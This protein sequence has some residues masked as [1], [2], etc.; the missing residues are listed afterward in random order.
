MSEVLTYEARDLN[1]TMALGRR[2]GEL[3][4]PGATVALIGPLGAGKTQLAGAIAEGLGISKGRHVCSPTFTLI[5]EYEARLPI[6]HFDTYRLRSAE[7]FIDLGVHEYFQ[8]NGVCL[9]EW[10][11]RVE[12]VLPPDHLRI[13]IE[14]MG[15]TQ[16]RFSIEGTGP[17]T[18]ALVR[19]L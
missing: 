12:S 16:R 8:G 6:F 3:L 7:E 11:D 5:Q 18:A 2:L 9:V 10:G 1:G 19:Q 4:G 13:S 15:E 17:T 14:V